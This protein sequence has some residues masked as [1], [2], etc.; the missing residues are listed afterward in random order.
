MPYQSEWSLLRSLTDNKWWKGCVE[1]EAFL[2]C[3]WEG[4]LV[5][6]LWKTVW[7]FLKKLIELPYDPA[8]PLLG[9]YLDKTIIQ[10][11]VCTPL[12][13]KSTIHNNQDMEAM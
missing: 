9:I 8:V 13:H 5:Q 3:L 4:K 6:P 1:K 11:A 12:H 7:S 2:H 10:K